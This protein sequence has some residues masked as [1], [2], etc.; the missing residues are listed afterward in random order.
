MYIPIMLQKLSKKLILT[1]LLL[2]LSV[3]VA[4]YLYWGSNSTK[5]QPQLIRTTTGSTANNAPIGELIIGDP[6]AP[7]TMVEYGDFKCPSCGEF[8]QAAW[9]DIKRDY[10]D[11]GRLKVIFKP[12]PVYGEDGAK[13]VYGSYCAAA[14]DK[15]TQYHEAAFAYMWENYFSKGDKDAS[16]RKTL[17][18]EALRSIVEPLGIDYAAFQNCIDEITYDSDYQQALSDAADDGVQGTPTFILN[19]QKV[20]GPQPYQIFKTLIDIQL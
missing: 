3:G 16:V 8:H 12:Y 6:A 4:G 11:T 1:S 15:F 5:S 14:Q 2:A 18:G 19:N 7:A 17:D 9:Q 13:A 20:V 10:I